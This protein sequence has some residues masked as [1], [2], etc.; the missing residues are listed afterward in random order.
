MIVVVVLKNKR[1]LYCSIDMAHMGQYIHD[2]SLRQLKQ[3]N[4]IIFVHRPCPAFVTNSIARS[5]PKKWKKKSKTNSSCR[6][7]WFVM[8]NFS[9]NDLAVPMTENNVYSLLCRHH[10]QTIGCEILYLIFESDLLDQN[11]RAAVLRS[12]NQ[13]S[14]VSHTLPPLLT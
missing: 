13:A 8:H 9:A 10:H 14:V 1:I 6:C 11:R 7:Y 5:V 4:K 2:W 12:F 3:N